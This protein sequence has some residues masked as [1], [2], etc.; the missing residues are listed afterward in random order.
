M[1]DPTN[2][3][4]VVELASRLMAEL[5]SQALADGRLAEL[6]MR[7]MYYLNT[8]ISME[9][10]TFSDLAHEL[11]VTKPSVTA[12]VGTLI[13]K[14]YIQKVQDHEDRRTYHMILTAKAV[15]F[16]RNHADVHKRL[17]DLLAAQLDEREVG[18]LARLLGK[19]LQAAKR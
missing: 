15:D 5:E 3:E 7:Q 6:S 12:I 18:Q 14:G 13:R 17:A 1:A 10:P 2:L 11:K 4:I 8:I 19:A 16:S 9:N